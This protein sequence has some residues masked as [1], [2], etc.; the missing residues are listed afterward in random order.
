VASRKL[1]ATPVWLGYRDFV[2]AEPKEIVETGY[3]RIAER[4]LAWIHEIRG[5]P[6]LQFLN[7]LIAR[8][9]AH[10]TSLDLVCGGDDLALL[11]RGGIR[12]GSVR[13][14]MAVR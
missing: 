6:R 14:G 13:L 5:D 4:H 9:P 1:C 2:A 12:C 11:R 7:D 3:D 10:P 8:L